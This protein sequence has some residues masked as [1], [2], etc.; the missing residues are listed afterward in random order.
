M[1]YAEEILKKLY[2]TLVETYCTDY[3]DESHEF[4]E[5]SATIRGRNTGRVGLSIVT[6]D[7]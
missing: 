2:D 5:L 3:L 4:V 1:A 6:L 7:L